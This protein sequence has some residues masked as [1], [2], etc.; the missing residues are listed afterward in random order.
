MNYHSLFQ[1]LSLSLWLFLCLC[2]NKQYTV[3]SVSK[4]DS[5][6]D[7]CLLTVRFMLRISLTDNISFVRKYKITGAKSYSKS[8]LVIFSF[9]LRACFSSNRYLRSIRLSQTVCFY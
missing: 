5:C 4:A 9:I 7:H 2:V 3:Y 8:F 6:N 1:L